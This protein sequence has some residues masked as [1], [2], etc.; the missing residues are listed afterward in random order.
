MRGAL[1]AFVIAVA[2]GATSCGATSD[3]EVSDDVPATAIADT[4][5]E[6]DIVE[7]EL[8]GGDGADDPI[9]AFQQTVNEVIGSADF[10]DVGEATLVDCPLTTWQELAPGASVNL[11]SNVAE[12]VQGS[13]DDG[14]DVFSPLLRCR[15]DLDNASTSTMV[16]LYS[17]MHF[18]SRT[19][20]TT[21]S[22]SPRLS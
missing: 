14:S 21:G 8:T 6:D 2:L 13:A 3:E 20:R 22:L 17:W 10:D 18:K 4:T 9:A 1:A 12:L 7:E 5:T 19:T 15:L 11:E 16:G